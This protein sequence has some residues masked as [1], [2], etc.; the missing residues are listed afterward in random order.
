MGNWSGK[1]YAV[2]GSWLC[3]CFL[4][5][6][7]KLT[8]WFSQKLHWNAKW[9]GASVTGLFFFDYLIKLCLRQQI[10]STLKIGSWSYLWN[11]LVLHTC[12]LAAA[13]F[14][15]QTNMH[16]FYFWSDYSILCPVKPALFSYCGI[17]IKASYVP[18]L[19]R[20]PHSVLCNSKYN[21]S[22]QSKLD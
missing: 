4:K 6:I 19:H 18:L 12:P 1:T 22:I 14:G 3:V 2:L 16:L 13:L 20:W 10:D 21:Y 7:I 9:A 5:T 8:N 11:H 15:V 17:Y